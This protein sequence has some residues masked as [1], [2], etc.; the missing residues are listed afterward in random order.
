MYS[1]KNKLALQAVGFGLKLIFTRPLQAISE[2]WDWLIT[3]LANEQLQRIKNNSL[4]A[5]LRLAYQRD[6]NF[7]T[8]SE[9][10]AEAGRKG[11]KANSKQN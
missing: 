3:P 8:L 10:R 4:P 2:L 7:T 11:G 1:N 5:E 9:I 6:W